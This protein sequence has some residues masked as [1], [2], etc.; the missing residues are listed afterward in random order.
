MQETLRSPLRV[1]AACRLNRQPCASSDVYCTRGM[2]EPLRKTRERASTL[3]YSAVWT[4]LLTSP[5]WVSRFRVTF[6]S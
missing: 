1:D 6:T 5:P 3:L 2:R 4:L